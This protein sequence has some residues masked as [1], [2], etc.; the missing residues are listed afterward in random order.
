MDANVV[1]ISVAL[2]FVGF[3]A[4]MAVIIAII[5]AVAAASADETV[6]A[7]DQ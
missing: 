1:A 4:L 3:M 2:G 7:R 5:S 6:G